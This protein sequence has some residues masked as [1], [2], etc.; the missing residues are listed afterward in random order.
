MAYLKIGEGCNRHCTYCIIPK[1]RGR[2]RSRTTADILAEAGNLIKEG[3][4][5]IV[6]IAQDTSAFGQ[7]LDGG[8]SLGGLL[9][10]LAQNADGTWFRFLYGSPDHTDAALIEA[11]ASHPR[12]LPYFDLPVQHVSDSVLKRMGR[13][14]REGDLLQLIGDIRRAIPGAALRTT[15]LVGFPGETEADFEQLLRFIE[16]VRFDHLGVFVYCDAEDLA[17]HALPDHVPEAVAGRRYEQL[18]SR[19]AEISLEKNRDRIGA[20][21]PVLVE[22]R[23]DSELY[24]GRT[25]FQAPEV[26]GVTYIETPNL[27]IGEFVDVRISQAYSYDLRGEVACPV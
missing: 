6:L 10:Q 18:M 2:L 5:E 23:I 15:L 16:K 1:L 13:Q 19:Q 4:R 20:V 7:D 3:F 26:D 9:R 25:E 24:I 11:V 22:E 8:Q 27:T 12:I 17:S 14:Y 21:Y